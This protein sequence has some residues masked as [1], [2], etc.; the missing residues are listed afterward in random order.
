M[1]CLLL[2]DAQLPISQKNQG[3]K[4]ENRAAARS[5][6]LNEIFMEMA[7]GGIEGNKGTQ[8][9]GKRK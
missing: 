1:R 4:Q 6:A 9:V 3:E 5:T 2:E 8:G 7:K